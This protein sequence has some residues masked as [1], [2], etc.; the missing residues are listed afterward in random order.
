MLL[1]LL[2]GCA[3]APKEPLLTPAQK[4]LNLDSFEYAWQTVNDTYWDPEFGGVDWPAVHDE[5][6]PRIEQ[7]TRMSED[8]AIMEDMI[9]RLGVSHFA[10]VPAVVYDIMGTD[11]GAGALDGTAGIDLRVIDLHALVTSVYPD[12]PAAQAGVRPGWEIIRI[13]ETDI[14]GR[15]QEVGKELADNPRR[16]ALLS[17]GVMSR[18][19]GSIGDTINA[20]FRD[21]DDRVVELDIQLVEKKGRKVKAANLPGTYIWIDTKRLP[22]DVGCIAFNGFLDPPYVMQ[23]YNDAMASFLDAKGVIIDLRGNGGG[24]GAMAMG[25]MGWLVQET[26]HPGTLYLRGH[27][28]KFLIEPRA[29]NYTGPVV[30][31]IDGLS[32]SA[33]EFFAGILKDIGR[34]QVIGSRSAGAVLGARLERLP[35]GDGFLYAAVNYEAKS[36]VV[37]EGVGVIPDTEVIPTRRALLEGRDPALE[38]ALGWIEVQSPADDSQAA[39]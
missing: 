9:S 18:L 31:L 12:S 27:E 32:A 11:A 26:Q 39:D 15:L 20:A 5:L 34:A 28:L 4:R 29:T 10:I 37:L 19:E 30:V 17:D 16:G 23:E 7:G 25:M 38:A 8:R 33:S 22:G 2:G 36:G 1:L 35:N 14:A 6:R 3:S 21:G 13:G 24:L